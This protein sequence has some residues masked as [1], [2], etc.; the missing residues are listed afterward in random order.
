MRRLPEEMDLPQSDL[1][2]AMVA[3]EV[4]STEREERIREASRGY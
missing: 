4:V 3:W 2:R 1:I